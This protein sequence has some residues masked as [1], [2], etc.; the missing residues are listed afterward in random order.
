MHWYSHLCTP[1]RFSLIC[2]THTQT[3]TMAYINHLIIGSASYAP[4]LIALCAVV[5]VAQCWQYISWEI[6]I[7]QN[8]TVSI[9][10]KCNVH[11]CVVVCDGRYK[12]SL[13][14]IICASVTIFNFYVVPSIYLYAHL[15]AVI[16]CEEHVD[17]LMV[18]LLI[19]ANAVYNLIT[20]MML[21]GTFPQD[22]SHSKLSTKFFFFT[23]V[24]Y[25]NALLK[26]FIRKK[27]PM[28]DV[29]M[30]PWRK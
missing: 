18:P 12:L 10:E 1:F 24:T 27:M 11:L 13:L 28:M 25:P 20:P 5:L 2:C 17:V 30:W 14:S 19:S 8:T 7:N 16:S 26:R 15:E 23:T 21:M 3:W 9:G 29:A 22:R 4:S 6:G